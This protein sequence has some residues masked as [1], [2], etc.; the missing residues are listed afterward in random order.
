VQ[1]I[2][3]GFNGGDDETWEESVKLG[4]IFFMFATILM[5]LWGVGAIVL[6]INDPIPR[7]GMVDQDD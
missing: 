5:V 2:P 1:F 6:A 7:W 4:K 3:F